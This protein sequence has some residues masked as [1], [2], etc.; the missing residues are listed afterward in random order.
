MSFDLAVWNDEVPLTHAQASEIYQRLCEEW[1]YLEGQSPHVEAFYQ[2]LIQR[3]PE[4]DTIL[5][6]RV[7]DIDLC[8]WSC[9]LNH[10]G[11]A[12]VI[13]CVWPKAAEVAQFVEKLAR[14]HRLVLFDPQANRVIL[15]EHL[16]PPKSG[17]FQR[18][19]RKPSDR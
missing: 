17:F 7:D 10:S 19:L 5:D 3:W 2:E 8:P 14:R 6:D 12:V 9:A 18:L 16:A 15:P 13:A 11:K 4:I 1:P